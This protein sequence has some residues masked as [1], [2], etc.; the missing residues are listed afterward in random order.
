VVKLDLLASENGA[1]AGPH[2]LPRQANTNMWY[3]IGLTREL[4]LS[5]NLMV[6]LL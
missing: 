5:L 6:L 4:D 3:P 2:R 1:R